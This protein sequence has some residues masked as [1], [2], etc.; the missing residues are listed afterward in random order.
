MISHNIF[1]YFE[2]TVSNIE[3]ET[4]QFLPIQRLDILGIV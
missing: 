1:I 2:D 4:L 3:T